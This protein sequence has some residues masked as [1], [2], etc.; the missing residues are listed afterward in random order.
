[1]TSR[2]ASPDPIGA[3]FSL[4]VPTEKPL[5][6][7]VTAFLFVL[8]VFALR[9]NKDNLPRLNPKKPFELTTRR[10]LEE[11]LAKGKEMLIQ[12]RETYGQKLYRLYSDF[13]D[14]VVLPAEFM[15][16]IRNNPA[17]S[18]LDA[19]NR[20]SMPRNRFSSMRHLVCSRTVPPKLTRLIFLL[21]TLTA[22]FLDSSPSASQKRPSIWSTE[23]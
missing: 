9:D 7:A 2:L 1:M 21:R 12:G 17:L 3:G 18:F 4:A 22:I 14:V 13:G 6:Y 19:A 11:Y 15:P 5:V 20:V 23:T 10:L 16:E 8:V